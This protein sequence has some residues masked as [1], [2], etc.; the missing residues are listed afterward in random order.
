MKSQSVELTL[1]I[2]IQ[3]TPRPRSRIGSS[4]VYMPT[5]YRYHQTALRATIAEYLTD[6]VD[7]P[8]DGAVAVYMSLDRRPGDLDNRIKTVLDVLAGLIYRDDSQVEQITAVIGRAEGTYLRVGPVD[9]GEVLDSGEVGVSTIL[10]AVSKVWLVPVEGLSGPSRAIHY[11]EAR[12][13]AALLLREIAGL[14]ISEIAKLLNRD[15]ASIRG[16]IARAQRATGPFAARI[17]L[18]RELLRS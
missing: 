6:D 10:T 18:V 9:S 11:C 2:S 12:H 1:P 14:R 15:R 16:G 4:A 8:M 13:A 17:E 5:G 3:P 7:L